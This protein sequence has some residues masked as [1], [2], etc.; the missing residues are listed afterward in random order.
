MTVTETRARVGAI[1]APP[2]SAHRSWA[3]MSWLRFRQHRIALLGLVLLGVIVGAVLAGTLLL[4]PNAAYFTDTSA[5]KH[6]NLVRSGVPLGQAVCRGDHL[7]NARRR[8]RDGS[9]ALDSHHC[10]TSLRTSC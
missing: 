7:P 6:L 1:A 5:L 4:P 8:S 9:L 3:Q 10:P 2:A